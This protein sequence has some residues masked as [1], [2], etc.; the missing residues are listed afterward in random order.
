MGKKDRIK[1]TGDHVKRA[2]ERTSDRL[3]GIRNATQ[4]A[5]YTPIQFAKDLGEAW[6]DGL[7]LMSAIMGGGG[8][9]Q[10]VIVLSGPIGTATG[11]NSPGGNKVTEDAVT[12]DEDLDSSLVIAPSRLVQVQGAD[13]IPADRITLTIEESGWGIKAELKSKQNPPDPNVTAG[14]YLGVITTSTNV[15][16]GQIQL[17]LF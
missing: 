12:L 6:V 8:S 17:W 11:Y 10:P 9:T 5:G 13:S 15:V 3:R 1:K 16:V 14:L 4:G 2:F 7:N